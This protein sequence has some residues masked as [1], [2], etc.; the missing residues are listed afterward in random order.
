MTKG[1]DS[2]WV[3]ID[4]L[5]KTTHFLPICEDDKMDKLAKL[6]IDEIVTRYG[7]RDRQKSYAD[8][9][10]KPLEFL[11]GDKKCLA[12]ESLHIPL[13]DMH[14]NESM[15]FVKKHVEI[16]DHGVKQLKCNRVSIVKGKSAPHPQALRP[17]I[18]FIPLT[19]IP[20]ATLDQ[21]RRYT[22][23]LVG[24]CCWWFLV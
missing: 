20:L 3:I 15:H 5:K 12:D 6:Y 8:K 23:L 13:D 4:R 16:M 22:R 2:I 7:A 17:T 14:I 21:L 11:V 10:R 19:E 18:P 9:S 1:H 24:A